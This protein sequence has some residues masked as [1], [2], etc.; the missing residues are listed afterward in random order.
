MTI[1][2]CYLALKANQGLSC[3]IFTSLQA[4]CAF[5]GITATSK[6]NAYLYP[7]LQGSIKLSLYVDQSPLVRRH[8]YSFGREI[9]VNCCTRSQDLALILASKVIPISLT[10]LMDAQRTHIFS[11]LAVMTKL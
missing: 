5:R 2:I 8:V 9:Q 1:D 6:V 11:F 10:K 7:D 3:G 4:L